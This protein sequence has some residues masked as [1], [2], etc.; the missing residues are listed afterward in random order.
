MVVD[1][2]GRSLESIKRKYSFD[3]SYYDL[4]NKRLARIGTPEETVTRKYLD[5]LLDSFP[6]KDDLDSLATDLQNLKYFF[7]L[8]NKRIV[9]LNPPVAGFDAVTKAYVD[10]KDKTTKT[11]I[12]AECEKVKGEAVAEGDNK[13]LAVKKELLTSLESAQKEVKE[14]LK[15][16]EEAIKVL[17]ENRRIDN[18]YVDALYAHLSITKSSVNVRETT[19][20]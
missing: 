15:S 8:E 7:D 20:G 3:A 2:F 12:R 4:E 18:L 13:R 11:Q 5:T 17:Q 16:I 9:R 19:R 6:T 1:K 10:S 14:K